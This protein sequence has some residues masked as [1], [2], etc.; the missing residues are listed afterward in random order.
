MTTATI[1]L[2]LAFAVGFARRAF[3][4]PSP[5]PRLILG[6]PLVMAMTVAYSVVDRRMMR[7]ARHAINCGGP[8]GIPPCQTSAYPEEH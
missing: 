7:P 2:V 3:G 8:S 1:G 6:A 5:V 4:I